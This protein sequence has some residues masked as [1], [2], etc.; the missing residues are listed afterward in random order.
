MA[1]P[2]A[3]S[4]F[5]TCGATGA[6]LAG[7]NEWFCVYSIFHPAEVLRVFGGFQVSNPCCQGTDVSR[8]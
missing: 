8:D 1:D 3:P 6:H 4:D 7:L 2:S 5:Q